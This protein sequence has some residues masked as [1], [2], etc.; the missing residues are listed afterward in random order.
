MKILST[1][2]RDGLTIISIGDDNGSEHKIELTSIEVQTLMASLQISHD[3]AI[4]HPDAGSTGYFGIARLQYTE[5]AKTL[6]FRVFL[7]D[8]VFHEYQVDADTNVGAE[9]KLLADRLE[10]RNSSKATGQLSG[11][12][13]GKAH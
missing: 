9:L 10:A 7:N 12:P 2:S 3:E 11:G 4:K 13:S 6:F 5:N 8:R 1:D